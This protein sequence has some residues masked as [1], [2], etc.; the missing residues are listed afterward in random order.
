MGAYCDT[1]GHA[2]SCAYCDTYGHANSCAYCDT[3][4]RANSYAYCD[5]YGHANSYAY[6]DTYGHANSYANCDTM[7]SHERLLPRTR[8]GGPEAKTIPEP[9]RFSVQ[10]ENHCRRNHGRCN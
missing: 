3:Y 2:N 9:P 1:Y 6:C 5:T 8:S 4:G 10:H 7:E